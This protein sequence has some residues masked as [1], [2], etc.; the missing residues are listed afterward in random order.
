MRPVPAKVPLY[1]VLPSPFFDS[2]DDD[3]DK[4]DFW[5]LQWRRKD[6][7][8]FHVIDRCTGT[9]RIFATSMAFMAI[10]S[11]NAYDTEGACV[12]RRAPTFE[13]YRCL[14]NFPCS[15]QFS[16]TLRDLPPSSLPRMPSSPPSRPQ[17]AG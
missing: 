16:A 15:P 12:N 13:Q 4:D 6:G 3:E 5:M 14:F 2:E 9:T 7:V 17:M 8:R 10:E 1:M 11:V